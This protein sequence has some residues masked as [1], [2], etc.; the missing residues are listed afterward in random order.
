M[1]RAVILL[2][3]FAAASAFAQEKQPSD[4]KELSDLLNIMQQETAVAT[5]TRINSDYVPGIVT[6][7]QGDQLEAMGVGTAGEALGL[8]PGMQAMMDPAGSPSVIVRGI[9]FPFNSGNI[10]VLINS[11]PLTRAD[12]GINASSLL[13]PVEQIERI[14]VIRGPGSVIYGDFAFMGLVNIVTRKE[15]DRLYGRG[16]QRRLGGGGFASGKSGAVSWSANV[17]HEA[18]KNAFSS[19][20]RAHDDR[21]FGVINLSNGGFSLL[22][23][24]AD[25]GF[26]PTGNGPHFDETSWVVDARYG[27]DVLPKLHTEAGVSYLHSDFTASNSAFVGH[28]LKYEGSVIF[29]RLQRQSWL[30][31]ADYSTST[32]DRALHSVPPVPGQPPPPLV[33]FAADA[34]RNITGITLQDRIELGDKFSVTLGARHD[35][36]SDLQSRTTPRAA[37]VFRATDRHIVKAQYSEG[38]R[39][40]TFFELYQTPAR[41]VVPRYPFEVNATTEL[42]YIFKSGGRL[43]RA[44]LFRT[45]VHD[46]IRPGGVVTTGETRS[47]GVE[48]EW[49]Q[50]LTA[51]LKLDTNTSHIST[52]DARAAGNPDMVSPEWLGN[53]ALVYQPLHDTFVGARLN[54]VGDRPTAGGYNLIDLTLSR[55]NLFI[56]GLGLRAGLKD[57]LNDH[58]VYLISRPVGDPLALLY[59]GRT[60]WMQ[61]SWSR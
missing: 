57:A 47:T 15:G 23:Q 28:V 42:N 54:Y 20:N 55:H 6:V 45:K 40:P 34:Q 1:K 29:D 7:L 5:K 3:L 31:G 53:A 14:E 39:P 48:G 11:V 27:R 26:A 44:T 43:A 4:E 22:A 50:Q 12:A 46:M 18:S 30:L 58:P 16:D 19:F 59:P 61:V 38:F 10:Q 17:S 32:I 8:V 24:E 13:I 25:R 35:S 9:D 21:T 36:Y 56:P 37:I 52:R 41:G 49:S 33:P 2:S 60:F 51:R